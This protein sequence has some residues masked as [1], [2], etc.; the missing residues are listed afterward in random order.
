[1]KITSISCINLSKDGGDAHTIRTNLLHRGLKE[2]NIALDIFSYSTNYDLNSTVHLGKYIFNNLNRKRFFMKKIGLLLNSFIFFRF[3][4]SIPKQNVI[5][6][7]KLEINL[8]LSFIFFKMIRRNVVVAQYH[9]F[10][11]FHNKPKNR[12]IQVIMKVHFILLKLLLKHI[13]LLIAISSIHGEYFKQFMR[14]KNIFVIPMLIDYKKDKNILTEKY[15]KHSP[16]RI[17]YGGA[18]SKSNGIELLIEATKN[19]HSIQLNIFGYCTPDYKNELYKKYGII[20]GDSKNN[21]EA[22]KI[23]ATQNLLVI[24]KIKDKR[25]LGYIPSKLGDF[26]MSGVPVLAT[27]VGIMDQYIFNNKNGFIVEPDNVNKMQEKILSIVNLKE[28]ELREIGINGM[29]SAEQF[30]YLPQIKALITSIQRLR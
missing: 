16:F 3:L 20:I 12:L 22:K 29:L 27:Q 14:K 2:Q 26:F 17:C 11:T 8:V 28:E 1:M 5:L 23:L 7:D 30:D 10:L 25:S 9:E 21:N 18:I 24:P 4:L 6:I 19:I 15:E 13:D